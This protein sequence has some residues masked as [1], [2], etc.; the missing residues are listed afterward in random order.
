MFQLTDPYRKGSTIFDPDPLAKH[1]QTHSHT[2]AGR[3][4]KDKK[5]ILDPGKNV[6]PFPQPPCYDPMK[7]SIQSVPS[8][9]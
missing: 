5:A 1:R 6:F 9:R 4:Y 3:C 8:L 2:H 7:R